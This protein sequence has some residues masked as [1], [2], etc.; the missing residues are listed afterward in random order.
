MANYL[1][2]EMESRR[3]RLTVFYF[4]NLILILISLYL[5]VVQWPDAWIFTEI[6]IALYGVFIAL[7]LIEMYRSKN[8]TGNEK[9][10]Y[11]I[12]LIFLGP[13]GGALYLL[14]PARKRF[15]HKI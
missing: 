5:N 6:A 11:G 14:R 12:A 13:V 1:F 15:T 2:L 9:W 3:K 10:M 8:L 4:F 7:C